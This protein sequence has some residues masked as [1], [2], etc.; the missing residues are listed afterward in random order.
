MRSAGEVMDYGNVLTSQG[1][2]RHCGL[3]LKSVYCGIYLGV[4]A[5]DYIYRV[6][7][8]DSI[9]SVSYVQCLDFRVCLCLMES[10]CE[11]LCQRPGMVVKSMRCG[12]CMNAV[13]HFW[14]LQSNSVHHVSSLFMRQTDSRYSAV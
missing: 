5:R 14:R 9:I 2:L 10:S 1:R 6:D 3:K 11:F 12:I 7:P 13:Q 8:R 4:I